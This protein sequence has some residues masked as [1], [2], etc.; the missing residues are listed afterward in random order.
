MYGKGEDHRYVRDALFSS[1]SNTSMT[2]AM[3][4]SV[5]RIVQTIPLATA[6]DVRP[7]SS[8]NRLGDGV[9]V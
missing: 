5:N 7:L 2:Y 1:S 3:L 9:D 8:S 4:D 6:F